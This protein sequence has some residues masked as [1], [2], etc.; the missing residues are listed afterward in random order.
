MIKS[1]QISNEKT[2]IT[3]KDIDTSIANAIRRS[4][5]SH[6]ETLA[7]DIIKVKENDGLLLDPILGHRLGLIPLK[8]SE[9]CRKGT[10]LLDIINDTN[11]MIT[12]YS[13]D[14]VPI[15]EK[16]LEVLE[17]PDFEVVDKKIIITKLDPG[18]KI[19]LIAEAIKGSGYTHAKWSPVAGPCYE[20]NEDGSYTYHIETLGSLTPKEI[21]VKAIEFLKEKLEKIEIN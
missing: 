5:I 18:Q 6:V 2:D 7:I 13:G 1:I 17:N 20:L 12:V 15:N 16:T 11:E 8:C 4:I 3:I 19:Y 9:L 14:L 21:F 10:F